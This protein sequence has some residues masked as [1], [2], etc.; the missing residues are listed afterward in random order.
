M[1]S[2]GQLG[3]GEEED[4]LEPALIK[5]K[6]L[7]ARMVLAASAGGQHTVLLATDKSKNSTPAAAQP[8]A[9]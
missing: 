2:N 9:Q 6:Q 4:V 5:G 7:E 3:H 8:I 1:G